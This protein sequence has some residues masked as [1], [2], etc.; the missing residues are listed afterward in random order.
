M[1]NLIRSKIAKF[2]QYFFLGNF[3]NDAFYLIYV[4]F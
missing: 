4:N 2:W 1:L 3:T